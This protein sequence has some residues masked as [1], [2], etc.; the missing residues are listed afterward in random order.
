VDLDRLIRDDTPQGDLDEILKMTVKK[1]GEIV[2]S[3]KRAGKKGYHQNTESE[4]KRV[5]KIHNRASEEVVFEAIENLEKLERSMAWGIV[6][7]TK[8][9]KVLAKCAYIPSL[10]RDVIKNPIVTKEIVESIKAQVDINKDTDI[11]AFEIKKGNYTNEEIHELY[12]KIRKIESSYYYD[13][14]DRDEVV[15]RKIY[16][17]KAWVESGQEIPR[18][19]QEEMLFL[20]K[21]ARIA[22]APVVSNIG[23]LAE[24][25]RDTRVMVHRAF[26][27][28]KNMSTKCHTWLLKS[29]DGDVMLGLA[30]NPM[31]STEDIH[32]RVTSV[33]YKTKEGYITSKSI[34]SQYL[35]GILNNP[36]TSKKNC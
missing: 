13:K 9:H 36:N 18:E 34:Y 5:M 11:V 12:S 21:E 8:Y 3:N 17:V 10:W 29:K 26:A 16:I 30:E 31:T 32:E 28:N 19:I 35:V 27:K 6:R 22:I 15:E 4:F 33:N 24:L 23:L 7:N 14:R 1:L 25:E 2:A 20:S